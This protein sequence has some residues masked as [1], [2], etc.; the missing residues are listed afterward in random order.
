MEDT[1]S[2]IKWCREDIQNL[3]EEQGKDSSE[4]AIDNFLEKFDLRYFEEMCIQSGWEILQSMIQ[5]RLTVEYLV[6]NIEQ[7]IL[8]VEHDLQLYPTVRYPGTV[9]FP[10]FSVYEKS[11]GIFCSL[12]CGSV[13][14]QTG[15][16]SRRTEK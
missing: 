5:M 2:Q 11:S 13:L 1:F 9:R 8:S 4:Q 7:K 15:I 12:S 16:L 10:G 3:L 6:E 14:L